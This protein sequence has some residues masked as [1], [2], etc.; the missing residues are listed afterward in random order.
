MA[1]PRGDV[2]EAVRT[3]PTE[4]ERLRDD[5]LDA[6]RASDFPGIDNGKPGHFRGPPPAA[7]FSPEAGGVGILAAA[8]IDPSTS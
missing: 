7:V 2:D 4:A 3:V 5:P 1:I 8:V 6:L